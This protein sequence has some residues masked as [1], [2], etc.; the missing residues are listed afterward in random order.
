MSAYLEIHLGHFR[1]QKGC[2]RQKHKT[3]SQKSS[4][5]AIKQARISLTE[6]LDSE[7]RFIYI[8]LF[9]TETAK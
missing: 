3:E 1:E 9:A 6:N 2:K 5:N 8:T 4:L 7:G